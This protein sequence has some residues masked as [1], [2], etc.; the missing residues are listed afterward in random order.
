MI[1]LWS[2]TFFWDGRASSLEEQALAPIRNPEEMGLGGNKA[3]EKLGRLPE[4]KAAFERAFG[5]SSVTMKN[6]A[7]AIALG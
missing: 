3:A 4:Y 2:H 7:K 6:I 1:V 5:A